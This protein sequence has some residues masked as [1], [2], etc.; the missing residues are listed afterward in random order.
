MDTMSNDSSG[1]LN[2]TLKFRTALPVI[3][4]IEDGFIKYEGEILLMLTGSPC[5]LTCLFQNV[6]SSSF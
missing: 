1:E 4:G 6:L 3:A 5:F 2:I